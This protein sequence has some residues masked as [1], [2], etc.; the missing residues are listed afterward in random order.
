MT[1]PRYTALF[2]VVHPSF[3]VTCNV[4]QRDRQPH[5]AAG[6]TAQSQSCCCWATIGPL[7]QGRWFPAIGYVVIIIDGGRFV[8]LVVRAADLSLLH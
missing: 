5:A 6:D 2:I 4:E 7:A 1:N 3:Y 8:A